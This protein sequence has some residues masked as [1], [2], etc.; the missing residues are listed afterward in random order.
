MRALVILLVVA[1]VARA[2]DKGLLDRGRTLEQQGKHAEAVA[3]YRAYV[4]TAPDDPVGNAELGFALFQLK[5]YAH[6]EAATRVAI[7]HAADDTLGAALFN[8]AMI[9]EAE[10]LPQ[11]AARSYA[12]SLQAR[13][14]R[15]ARERLQKLDPGAAA[16]LDPLAPVLLAG[17]FALIRDACRDWNVRHGMSADDTWG[18]HGSCDNVDKIAIRDASKLRAPFQAVEAFQ[19]IDRSSLEIAVKLPAGWF[20]F[21][22]NGKGRRSQAH[23]GGTD[24]SVTAVSVT[25]RA[26]TEL[27]LAYDSRGSCFHRIDSWEW[28][29]RGTILIG[30]GPSGR[31]SAP[32]PLISRQLERGEGDSGKHYVQTDASL[33]YALP[34]DG[35]IVVSGT[36]AHPTWTTPHSHDPED[37][38]ADNVLGRHVVVFP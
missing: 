4:A 11:D 24:F 2:D 20:L 8:L 33:A 16:K 36:V 13:P 15:V 31:P 23:C 6:A 25:T 14:S 32:P 27:R 1:G 12:Q 30:I 17:P 29:E 35:T 10:K 19:L 9:Q 18:E 5:D 21:H 34:A 7:A 37:L 22:A 26:A 38:D 3:A 28:D